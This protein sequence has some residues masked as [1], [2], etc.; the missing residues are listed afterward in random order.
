MPLI[1]GDRTHF[2]VSS[3]PKV[4]LGSSPFGVISAAVKNLSHL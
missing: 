4:S 3:E 1:L 2:A